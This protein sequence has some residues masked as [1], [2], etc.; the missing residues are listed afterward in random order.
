MKQRVKEHR[1]QEVTKQQPADL[2]RRR[3][4]HPKVLDT[5]TIA[6]IPRQDKLGDKP[7]KQ[8]PSYNSLIPDPKQELAI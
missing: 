4:A 7:R 5:V 8:K 3:Q 2:K 1:L 6:E